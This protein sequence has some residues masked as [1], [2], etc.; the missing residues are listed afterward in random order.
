[1]AYLESFIGGLITAFIFNKIAF[2]NILNA[3]W[4]ANK[5]ILFILK[6]ELSDDDK[7][8]RLLANC[9]HLFKVSC[10]LLFSSTVVV[11]P[12]VLLYWITLNKSEE[13]HFKLCVSLI[14]LIGIL[15]GIYLFP[16]K[17]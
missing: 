7:H 13:D 3:I 2:S 11:F 10:Q 16:K 8:V 1:V 6:S 4:R 17:K 5:G 12:S 15:G 9:G 14:N